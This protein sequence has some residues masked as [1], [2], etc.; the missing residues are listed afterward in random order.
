MS[1][2]VRAFRRS[3]GQF[4]TGVAV[5]TAQNPGGEAVGMTMSSFNSVSLDP[6]LILFSVDRNAYSLPEML[7]A[8]G[9]AV[10]ILSRGQEHLSNQFA[11]ALSDKWAAVEHTLGHTEAPLIH[12]A[13]A[14]FER[15]PY[16][17]Y[18]GGDHVIFV[19]KVLSF[20]ASENP[21]DQ[22]LIFW[23]GKYHALE[24]GEESAPLW[25]LPMHY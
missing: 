6:P 18:E 14:H 25:P 19:G 24:A 13:L 5:I 3:L 22:P 15:E 11:K 2:D 23:R 8:K 10:N 1:F 12:G 7:E 9:Y 4:A 21:K 20:S 17:H 16:A